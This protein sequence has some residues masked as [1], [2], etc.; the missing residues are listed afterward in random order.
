MT[1]NEWKV[2]CNKPDRVFGK[3]VDLPRR[4][5]GKGWKACSKVIMKLGKERNFS[6]GFQYT[7]L[8]RQA[9]NFEIC[10]YDIHDIGEELLDCQKLNSF[11]KEIENNI[12]DELKWH[13]DRWKRDEFLSS[14][15]H[16]ELKTYVE[17]ILLYEDIAEIKTLLKK[18]TYLIWTDE[19]SYF[20]LHK[21]SGLF[22]PN[23]LKIIYSFF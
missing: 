12:T 16:G 11:T 14:L 15:K 13:E 17:N 18:F 20:H 9:C 6:W 8:I 5:I 19:N 22:E 1:S 2:V 23:L 3:R 7:K 10:T 21:N 4:F